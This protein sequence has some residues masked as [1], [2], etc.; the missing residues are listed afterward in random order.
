MILLNHWY[1]LSFIFGHV[2]V[3][4]CLV[5]SLYCIMVLVLCHGHAHE[6]R[7]KSRILYGK[8]YCKVQVFQK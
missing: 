5:V 2:C 6:Q 7:E 8:D 1:S 4:W 3:L